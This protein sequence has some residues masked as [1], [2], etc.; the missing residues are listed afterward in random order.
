MNNNNNPIEPARFNTDKTIKPAAFTPVSAATARTGKRPRMGVL[1]TG[2]VLLLCATVVWF[3]FTAKSIYIETDPPDAIVAIQ[4]GIKIKLARHYL[5]HSGKYRISAN[6]P[7][8]FPLDQ[9][10]VIDNDQE[11]HFAFALQ[12]LPGHLNLSSSPVT[13]AEI[14]I[15]DALKG[16]TPMTVSNLSPGTHTLKIAAERYLPYEGTV[17]IEGLGHEQILSVNLVPAWADVTLSSQPPGAQVYI[18]NSPVGQTPVTAEVMQGKHDV[19][20]KLPGYKVW[21]ESLRITANEPLNLSEIKLK[22]ADALLFI[23]TRP[24]KVD[25]T[26]A[27][28]YKGQTPV[29]VALAPGKPADIHFF[30]EG[31]QKASRKL[32]LKSGEK[33]RLRVELKPEL[34]PVLFAVEPADARLYVDGV[35][36]G[37][38]MQTLQLSTRSHQ[39]EI[40]K[41]GYVPYRTTIIPRTG[42][43]QQLRVKLKTL[44]QA[45]LESIKPIIKTPANQIM[46]LFYPG[47]FTMGASRREAGRRANETLRNIALTRPFYLSLREVTNAEY[48]AFD[49]SHSSGNVQGNSLNGNRQPVVK[50]SWEQA[51]LYCNWLSRQESLPPFYQVKGNKV[52]GFD[53]N[54]IG[55]RLP[56][57]AEWAW[58]AR[59]TGKQQMLKFPWGSKFPPKAVSGNY[60]DTSAAQLLGRIIG[61]YND[62]YA[63]TAPVGSFAANS[64]GLFDM[65]GNV[66]EWT[67]DFY[68][69]AIGRSNAFEKDPMGP[70]T[71]EN[72]VIRGSSWA[73]G[74]ITELRLSYRD[75][76]N[77]ARDDVG[78]RLARYME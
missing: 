72:H 28:Q 22:V 62:G 16:R 32:T 14:W 59:T 54:A 68:D 36:R 3:V 12:R 50:I 44:R 4:G 70:E 15:D 55:Y 20:I 27:G 74:S 48:R 29:E 56:T 25:I 53:R 76:G 13:G 5:I 23:E 69:I 42:V 65:G 60:A 40:L 7:G 35:L 11:Q 24:A 19:R 2:I 6:A 21:Q 75:Y 47:K 73:H 71:G 9:A 46:K 51:A 34:M 26:V 43:A 8:Y 66:A 41:E 10:L 63:T 45:R 37:H 67:N 57:E 38:P 17:E 18:D 58:A 33:R 77:K 30:K 39:I 78:F 52:T 61:R 64:K 1:L 49:R 31:Y